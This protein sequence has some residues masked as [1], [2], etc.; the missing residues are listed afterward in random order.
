MVRII[1]EVLNYSM[2]EKY[3][4]RIQKEKIIVHEV[5]FI[6][7]WQNLKTGLFNFS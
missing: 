2:D 5:D 6:A 7:F 3:G 1:E 4:I